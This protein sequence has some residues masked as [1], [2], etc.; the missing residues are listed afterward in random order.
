MYTGAVSERSHLSLVLVNKDVVLVLGTTAP[1]YPNKTL[2]VYF[3]I[4]LL[5]V[6]L[7]GNSMMC[8]T[9]EVS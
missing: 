4:M 7:V 8:L 5:F 2:L 1:F 6:V 3:T 9:S